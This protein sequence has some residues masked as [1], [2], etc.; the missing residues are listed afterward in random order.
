MGALPIILTAWDKYKENCEPFK[1]WWRFEEML[2]RFLLPIRCQ[3]VI[4]KQN[5]QQLLAPIVDTDEILEEMLQDGDSAWWADSG[6]DSALRERL[7][8]A[9]DVYI[10]M[11]SD[12]RRQ[13]KKIHEVLDVAP[14]NTGWLT[15]PKAD[16]K[17]QYKRLRV[18]FKKPQILSYA[19]RF[20]EDNC[21]ISR[22]LENET[23]LTPATRRKQSP[24]SKILQEVRR[25]AASLYT[26]L[27]QGWLCSCKDPHAAILRLE[28]RPVKASRRT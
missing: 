19:K 9:Y 15:D 28:Q 2:S 22:L 3:Q 25:A 8:D 4:F 10:D 1:D 14:G 5:L 6:M 12:M 24:V 23:R 27:S 21:Q 18:C 17:R 13:L 26:A 7:G 11:I 16:W 20:E